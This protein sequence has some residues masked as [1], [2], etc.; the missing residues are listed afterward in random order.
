[1]EIAQPD[2]WR[3]CWNVNLVKETGFHPFIEI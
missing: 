3:L 1:M 2:E